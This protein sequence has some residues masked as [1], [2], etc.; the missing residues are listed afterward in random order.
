MFTNATALSPGCN[1]AGDKVL[2]LVLVLVLVMAFLGG[3]AAAAGA[4]HNIGDLVT[5][6]KGAAAAS[7]N[8][9]L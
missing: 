1:L 9:E 6:R 7:R 4:V 8:W 3:K 5:L 2:V